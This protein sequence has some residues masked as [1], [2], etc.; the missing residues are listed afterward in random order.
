MET[1]FWVIYVELQDYGS[2]KDII[3]IITD[4]KVFKKL[5][6]EKYGIKTQPKKDYYGNGSLYYEYSV[7]RL[8]KYTEYYHLIA[9]PVKQII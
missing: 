7:K 1:K 4:L 3:G 9:E 5:A 2:S 6:K 8:E